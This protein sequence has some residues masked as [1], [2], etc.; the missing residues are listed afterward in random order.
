M[1]LY[2]W[3]EMMQ[4]YREILNPDLDALDD[5]PKEKRETIKKQVK[6][7]FKQN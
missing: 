5:L 3:L 2:E 7:A 1:E 4:W 6:N